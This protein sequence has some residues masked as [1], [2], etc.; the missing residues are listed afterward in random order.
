M[1]RVA[2]ILGALLLGA[3]FLLGWHLSTVRHEGWR[4][5]RDVALANLVETRA[6]VAASEAAADTLRRSVA[7]FADRAA[8]QDAAVALERRQAQASAAALRQFRDS[9]TAATVPV[10]VLDTALAV[11]AQQEVVIAEQD[12]AIAIRDRQIQAGAE[13]RAEVERQRDQWKGAAEE[14]GQVLKDYRAPSRPKLL[15]LLPAPSPTVTF[16]V[17]AAIGV[18]ATR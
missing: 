14:L 2:W 9:V 15:G 3:A 13:L 12:K 6:K 1:S 16:L 4:V 18:V 8:R 7:D 10:S 5:E 17:G 11:V